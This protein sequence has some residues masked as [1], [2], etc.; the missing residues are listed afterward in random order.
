MKK[1]HHLFVENMCSFVLSL[2]MF[3]LNVVAI[4]HSEFLSS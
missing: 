2:L 1:F 4:N 3:K